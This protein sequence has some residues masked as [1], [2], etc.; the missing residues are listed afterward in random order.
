MSPTNVSLGRLAEL[1]ADVRDEILTSYDRGVL[2]LALSPEETR[3]R[4]VFTH[5]ASIE[6][7]DEQRAADDHERWGYY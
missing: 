1:T 6:G 7:F 3:R 5:G 2:R 4:Y